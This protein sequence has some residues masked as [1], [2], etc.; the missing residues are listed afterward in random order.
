MQD[1]MNTI[2]L[3]QNWDMAVDISGNIALASSPYALAQDAASECRLF[4]G[5]CYY[6]TT[7]G[8]QYWRDILG[9]YPPLE[10]MRTYYKNAAMLVPTVVKSKVFFSGLQNRT[11][12]VQV[13]VT[14]N[15]G[16]VSA[17]GF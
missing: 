16:L 17:L 11:L 4:Y 5:E 14:D 7:R 3:N 1:N 6:D 12:T 9:K 15:A 13:Q 8:V 2:Y 10:L